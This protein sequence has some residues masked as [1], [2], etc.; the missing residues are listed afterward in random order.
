[1]G[2]NIIVS[3]SEKAL[4]MPSMQFDLIL[5]GGTA[6]TSAGRVDVEIGIKDGKTMAIGDL[7]TADAVER[8]DCSGLHILPG[9]IDSQ[10]HFREPGN[11]H[12]EDLAHGSAGAAAGGVTAFFEMPNTSPLTITEEAIQ[13]K[14]DRA[15]GRSWTDYAFYVGG[16]TANVDTLPELEK[17]PGICGVKIFMGASTGDLLSPDDATIEK[18]LRAGNRIVAVHAEDN[19]RLE[20]RAHMVAGGAPVTMHPE[21]R[22]VEVCLKATQRVLNLAEKTGRRV[23]VLHITTGQEMALLAQHKHIASVEVLAN[24][25]TLA[26]PEDYERLGSLAQQ[27]PPIRDASQRAALWQALAAGIVDVV[28]TDHAPHTLEEKARPY[29]QSPSG[30]PGVQTLVPVMLDH[31]NA[32]RLTLERFV[33]LTSAS[34]ARLYRVTGKGRIAVGYDADFTIVDMNAK[35]EIT[36]DWIK[37]KSQWTPFDGKIVQGWPIAT[38]IRGNTVMRE[39][40]L[41]DSPIGR[42]VQ[43]Q[44]T[45]NPVG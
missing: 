3:N 26:G 9:V 1:M 17:K 29:P 11:E 21:W 37:S 45:I 12:K 5:T 10:V 22:D 6:L 24:H 39:D 30:M 41:I 35:R 16:S 32:G 18:I 42:P 34:P 27:N 8:M 13:D 2:S 23:H 25:L 36:N 14:L 20:E 40:A 15:H 33:D 31:V 7:R 4:I 43:F 44:E 28:A 19:A 38:I